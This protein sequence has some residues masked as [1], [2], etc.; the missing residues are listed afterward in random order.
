MLFQIT[1]QA[2]GI[3]G[4]VF[5]KLRLSEEKTKLKDKKRQNSHITHML[6]MWKAAKDERMK[7]EKRCS[8]WI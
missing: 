2:W 4:F 5:A 8:K 7:N 1:V 6:V 3:F